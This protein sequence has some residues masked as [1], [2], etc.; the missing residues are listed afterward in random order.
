[1][2]YLKYIFRI[3]SFVRILRQT[4]SPTVSLGEGD[5]FVSSVYSAFIKQPFL[6]FSVSFHNLLNYAD[7][8]AEIDLV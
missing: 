3:K 4:V 2:N 5:Y 8:A 6:S 7:F 1:M